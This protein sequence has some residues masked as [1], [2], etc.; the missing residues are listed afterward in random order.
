M[1]LQP[2]TT[3]HLGIIA[4]WRSNQG[5][6]FLDFG[7]TRLFLHARDLEM[8]R[9]PRAG[10]K[11]R[12]TV[13][14][15]AKGRLCAKNAVPLRG[16]SGSLGV[17]SACAL[18]ALLVL[19]AKALW[20]LRFDTYWTLVYALAI[21]LMTYASYANDKRRARTKAWRIPEVN[22]HLMELL[23]G[24]PG[25]WVAQ[26]RFRHKTSKPSYQ[27]TF[28]FIILTHQGVAYDALQGWKFFHALVRWI[29]K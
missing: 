15:D 12:F 25:A 29:A 18:F 20:H 11:I 13:G 24:W 1:I 14:T 21:N 16:G 22:L 3:E 7:S 9:A 23:G 10:D 17:F 19:P 5:Y 27:F 28:W 26:R 6:G 4:E 8:N 2:S